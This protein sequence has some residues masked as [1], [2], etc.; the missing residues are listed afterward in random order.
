MQSFTYGSRIV[1]NELNARLNR[2]VKRLGNAVRAVVKLLATVFIFVVLSAALSRISHYNFLSLDTLRMVSES[3]HIYN[4][5]LST[6]S[7]L[8]QHILCFLFALVC[9]YAREIATLID[10]IV[11]RTEKE[12][13]RESSTIH[14]SFA[15][16]EVAAKRA[17]SYRHK[18]CFLS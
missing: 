13:S 7:Y 11:G 15:Q 9:V 10:A 17:V 5:S 1:I 18:V 16:S 4:G 2:N 14:S 6:I 8:Y 3:A 12:L